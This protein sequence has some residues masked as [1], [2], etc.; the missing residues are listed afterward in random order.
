MH[1]QHCNATEPDVIKQRTSK[2]G[3]MRL[4]CKRCQNWSKNIDAPKVLLFD[5]ETSRIHIETDMWA[6]DFR[7]EKRLK[8]ADIKEDWYILSWAGSWLFSGEA[9]GGVVTP[10]EAKRRDDQRITRS[11]H[12]Y[13]KRADIVITHNGN[14]FDIKKINWRFLMHYLEPTHRYHSIDTLA[15]SKQVF[16]VTSYAMDFM[17]RQLG[18]DTKHHTNLELWENC[19]AGK[20]AALNEMLVYNKNDVFMLEDLYLRIRGWMITHP[21]MTYLA[22]MYQPLGPDEYR[23]KRCGEVINKSKFSQKYTTPGGF[24][25]AT[26]NCPEC[27]AMLRQ[28][29]RI[30]GQSVRVR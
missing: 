3:M 5:I 16:G 18:Y 22:E 6:G 20:Q 25:Y 1:C 14:R 21:N 7:H 10:A 12:K 15:K 4:Y 17:C 13:I 23:C 28:T 26:C 2:Y 29:K 27:G 9:F 8:H 11:L 30:P 24:I 19:E